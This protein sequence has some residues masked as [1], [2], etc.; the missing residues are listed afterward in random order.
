MLISET[1]PRKTDQ[2]TSRLDDR[3]FTLI[4]VLIVVFIIGLMSSLVLFSLPERPPEVHREVDRTMRIFKLAA[5]EAI[6]SGEPVAWRQ[7]DGGHE[8]RRYRFGKWQY[9]STGPLTRVQDLEYSEG[10]S[11]EIIRSAQDERDRSDRDRRRDDEDEGPPP[12]EPDLV[13]F[14]TGES[15]DVLLRITGREG[16]E[17]VSVKPGGVIFSGA[18]EVSAYGR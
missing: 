17:Y 12:F 9:L 8:F 16:V 11:L 18:T 5:R 7:G 6:A 14:P 4:E 15:N 2:L 1:G 10:V 3:G 13:F